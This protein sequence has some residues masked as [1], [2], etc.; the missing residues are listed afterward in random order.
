MKHSFSG[1]ITATGFYHAFLGAMKKEKYQSNPHTILILE[2]YSERTGLMGSGGCPPVEWAHSR[3]NWSPA[4]AAG[5]TQLR[6]QRRIRNLPLPPA[7]RPDWETLRLLKVLNTPVPG[8]SPPVPSEG[9]LALHLKETSRLIENSL[10]I[11]S[12]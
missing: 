10:Q 5:H 2:T 3:G 12:D 1:L 11:G 8:L 7:T 4:H 9:V 6:P